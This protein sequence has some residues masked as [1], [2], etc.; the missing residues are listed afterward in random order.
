M[1]STE[2]AFIPVS[3][4]KL[5]PDINR[6]IARSVRPASKKHELTR[7]LQALIYYF[8][9]SHVLLRFPRTERLGGCGSSRQRETDHFNLTNGSLW[10]SPL[11][12]DRVAQCAC[13]YPRFSSRPLSIYRSAIAAPPADNKLLLSSLYKKPPP[14]TPTIQSIDRAQLFELG[15]AIDRHRRN[16]PSRYLVSGKRVQSMPP[17]ATATKDSAAAV[18]AARRFAGAC[19][20]LSYFV[21]SAG[22]VP[23]AM[24]MSAFGAAARVGAMQEPDGPPADGAQQL[25]IF[26][27]GRVVVLDG[28]TPARAAELIRYAAAAAAAPSAET[29]AT[30]ALVDIPIARKMSLQRFLSKRKDRSV[31][32]ADEEAAAPAPAK[33]GQTEASS[34]LALGSLGDMH[35]E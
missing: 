27:G 35:A 22:P 18:A 3:K 8:T 5:H 30:A 21:K 6:Q 1:Q 23:M 7:E 17:M 34:W 12:V 28:C 29:P 11:L 4:T 31:A 24:P 33:K 19:G 25:T 16:P 14:R 26:Y 10:L 32:T 13:Q 20:M 2:L 9:A 15:E